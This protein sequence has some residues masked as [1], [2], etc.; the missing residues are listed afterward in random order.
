MTCA[1]AP[2]SIDPWSK[3]DLH[4]GADMRTLSHKHTWKQ[5]RR[6]PAGPDREHTHRTPYFL[7]K[8]APSMTQARLVISQRLLATGPA[9][10]N[11]ALLGDRSWKP[12]SLVRA[13][14][15]SGK[16]E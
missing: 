16:V 10:A 8:A 9:T 12:G 6:G 4:A 1:Q 5:Y 7:L 14:T 3:P 15:A 2:S 13:V 11:A